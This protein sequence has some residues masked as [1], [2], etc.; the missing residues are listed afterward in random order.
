V[1]PQ[2][3]AGAQQLGAGAQ[4]GAGAQHDGAGA[5]AGA[6]QLGA[7]AGAGAGAQVG[8]GA[9]QLGAGAQQLGAGAAHVG[10]HP[11]P[12]PWC[13]P[14]FAVLTAAQQNNIAKEQLNHFMTS[15]LLV[16]PSRFGFEREE[17]RGSCRSGESASPGSGVLFSHHTVAN[18]NCNSAG[19]SLAGDGNHEE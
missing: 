12:H 13:Q 18:T 16:T 15:L 11:Q 2:V 4:A 19:V 10:A 3:G 8:A 5:G 14:A 17:P 6:Q 9:A 7:G 1:Q